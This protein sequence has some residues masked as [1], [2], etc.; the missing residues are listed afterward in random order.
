MQKSE[1]YNNEIWKPIE[2]PNNIKPYYMIS[3]HG[4]VKNI[5]TGKILKPYASK[6][7]RCCYLYVSL[8]TYSKNIDTGQTVIMKFTVHS[9][10]LSNFTDD[11]EKLWDSRFIINHKD[12]NKQNPKL[13]NLEWVTYRGNAVHAKE[14][15]L[16][17]VG[18]QCPNSKVTNDTV[19]RICELLER[20]IDY[21]TIA[22]E[23]NLPWDDYAK[24]LLVRIRKRIQWTE[25]SKDYNF[26]SST[27]LRKYSEELV[28]NICKSLELGLTTSEIRKIYAPDIDFG[29][30]KG[31]VYCIRTR[32][33]FQDISKDYK[34]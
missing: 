18:D 9:L 33:T 14:T 11:Y 1:S 2:I 30:F 4:R 22:K 31:L 12:G 29:K 19:R 26:D 10:V 23:L 15:G 32:Q 13:S 21:K 5:K 8:P 28:R 20:D 34:W 24:S 25:I 17:K 27:R 16:T 7:S 6:S 3:D